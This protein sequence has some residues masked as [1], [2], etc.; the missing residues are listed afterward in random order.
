MSTELKVGFTAAYI[1]DCGFRYIT[2]I[3][4]IVAVQW[5]KL[6]VPKARIAGVPVEDITEDSW[7]NKSFI[8]IDQEYGAFIALYN[9]DGVFSVRRKEL[10]KVS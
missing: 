6:A 4:A 8:I 1:N 2:E 3:P 5:V 7:E 10:N 9:H